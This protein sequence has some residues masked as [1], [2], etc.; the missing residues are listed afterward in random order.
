MPDIG[1]DHRRIELPITNYQLPFPQPGTPTKI[2]LTGPLSIRGLSLVDQRSGAFQSLTLGPYRLVHSGDVKVYE[3]LANLPRAFVASNMVVIPDDTQARAALADPGFDPAGTVILASAPP[4]PPET[5]GISATRP[6]TITSY[7]PEQVLLTA[8]GPGQLLLTDA[9]YPGWTA[10]VDGA[11]AAIERAD[12]MFRGLSLS[13]GQHQIEFR[14]NPRS[15]WIG[16]LVSG[17]AW[18][19]LAVIALAINIQK[20]M[21]IVRGA[22]WRSTSLF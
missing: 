19:A 21:S 5:S 1:E 9:Y 17:L 16:L 15:V 10:T 3:N 12:I 6:V 13:R 11:P 18:A 8:D 14:Y 4:T 20:E 2:I 7:S 22:P